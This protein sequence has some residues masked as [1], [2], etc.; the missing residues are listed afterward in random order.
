MSYYDK[1]LF[2]KKL[3]VQFNNNNIVNI[4]SVPAKDVYKLAA[5]IFDTQKSGKRL[6]KLTTFYLLTVITLYNHSSSNLN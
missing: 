3:F 1:Y 2:F 5:L 6:I 4:F